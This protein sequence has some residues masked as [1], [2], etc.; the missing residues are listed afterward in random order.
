MAML[1]ELVDGVIG[2]DTHPGHPDRRRRH[3]PGRGAGPDHHPRRCGRLPA[4]AGLRPHAGSRPSLLGGRGDRQLRHRA[5]RVPAAARRASRRDGSAQAAG[6]P[7]WRQERR[8]GRG[9]SRPRGA[10]PGPWAHSDPTPAW[11]AGSTAGAA[12]H[13]TQRDPCPCSCD[14]S[15]QGADRGCPGGAAGRAARPQHNPTRSPPAPA[16]GSGRPGRWNTAPPS[17]PCGQPPSASRPSKP[18]PTSSRPSWPSWSVQ[19]L[20]G[21]SRFL[22]SGR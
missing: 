2:V 8:A 7:D 20:R 18:R 16:C 9:P 22:V 5:G 6:L 19:S 10:G 1:A 21:C 3:P 4:A 17:A 15:A 11:R 12:D 14:R 13:P